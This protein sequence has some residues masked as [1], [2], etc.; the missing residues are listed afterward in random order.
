M[1]PY[2]LAG[3][4]S[5]HAERFPERP[6]LLWGEETLTYAELDRRAARTA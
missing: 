2:N 6:C 3:V 5:H 4:L 1:S